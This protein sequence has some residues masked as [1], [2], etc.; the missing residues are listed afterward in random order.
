VL[1]LDS[2][3][4]LA[5]RAI[6]SALSTGRPVVAFEEISS[7][8]GLVARINRLDKTA[9]NR[10]WSRNLDPVSGFIRPRFYRRDLLL[11][12]LRKIP[13]SIM[14]V[15]PCPFSED[16]LIYWHTEVSPDQVGFI[17]NAIFHE[18]E[19]YLLA[20]LRKWRKYGETAKVYRGTPYSILVANR[21]KRSVRGIWRVATA[22][23]LLL[24][25]APFI[26]GYY[27]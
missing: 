8:E 26:V 22:P 11:H 4:I 2:D 21:G 10:E 19:S 23:G 20:Y 14:D 9:V 24:R 18:E 25:A 1:N 17:R 13:A 5:P 27:I 6:E 3:Q 16:S 7:G 15:R 12:A